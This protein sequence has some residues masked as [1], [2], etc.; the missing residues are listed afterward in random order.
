MSPQAIGLIWLFIFGVLGL[1]LIWI[2]LVF[3]IMNKDICPICK[4]SE[5]R[6]ETTVTAKNGQVKY[7]QVCKQCF[8]ECEEK[9]DDDE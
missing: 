4:K 8:R 6:Y 1:L 9:V 3:R 7:I 5:A 2:D